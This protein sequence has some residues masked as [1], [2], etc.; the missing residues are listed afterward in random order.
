MGTEMGLHKSLDG[1]LS[2]T[3]SPFPCFNWVICFRIWLG[4]CPNKEI[5]CVEIPQTFNHLSS[6]HSSCI[7]QS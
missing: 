5:D 1:R 4:Q 6:E 7:I 2:F 3:A